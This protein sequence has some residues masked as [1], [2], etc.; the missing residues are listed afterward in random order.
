MGGPIVP[1][2]L[3]MHSEHHQQDL[4]LFEKRL[5]AGG[6]A[7]VRR[8]VIAIFFLF[9]H[10]IQLNTASIHAEYYNLLLSFKLIKYI[11]FVKMNATYIM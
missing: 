10:I 6:S 5:L 1:A 8:R 4:M 3:C 7:Y 9:I 11:S 2:P